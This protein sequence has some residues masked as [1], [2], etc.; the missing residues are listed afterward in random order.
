MADL[1]P[2][3]KNL[4]SLTQDRQAIIVYQAIVTEKGLSVEDLRAFTLFLR[5]YITRA[6]AGS[7]FHSLSEIGR[8]IGKAAKPYNQRNEKK[9]SIL[10]TDYNK[11][12]YILKRLLDEKGLIQKMEQQAEILAYNDLFGENRPLPR[13]IHKEA[14]APAFGLDI[15]L[16]NKGLTVEVVERA[17]SL[18]AFKEEATASTLPL[19]LTTAAVP[20][21]SKE[22]NTRRDCWELM[23]HYLDLNVTAD[24]LKEL[25][26][27]N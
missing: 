9:G 27:G 4:A 10:S 8:L 17:L 6:R 3:K 23:N 2:L 20:G 13:Q 12:Y 24:D 1:Q 25:I 19:F 15:T 14:Y 5:L 22:E 21:V 11:I 26:G 7:H 16:R 18:Y